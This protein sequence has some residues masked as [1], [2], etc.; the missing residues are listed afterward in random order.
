M[1]FFKDVLPAGKG[2]GTALGAMETV[3]PDV[4][5]GYVGDVMSGEDILGDFVRHG[6]QVGAVVDQVGDQGLEGLGIGGVG[7]DEVLGIVHDA[8]L[9]MQ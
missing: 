4:V 9:G 5:R 2:L 1:G 6:V 8:F 3:P 7:Q